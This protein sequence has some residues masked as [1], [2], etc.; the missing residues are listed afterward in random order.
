MDLNCQTLDTTVPHVPAEAGGLQS[1]TGTRRQ[2][3]A[4]DLRAQTYPL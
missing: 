2:R 1:W 3:E 4:G